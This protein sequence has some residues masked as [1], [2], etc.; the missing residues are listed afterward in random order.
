MWI[1]PNVS[2]HG[3]K[4][5]V[6]LEN[7]LYLEIAKANDG[8]DPDRLAVYAVFSAEHRIPLV[9]V[10]DSSSGGSSVDGYKHAQ[11]Y[12]ARIFEGVKGGYKILDLNE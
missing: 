5:A 1:I 2:G 7:A 12:I 8:R 9:E 11:G 6:N 4:P 10:I 3:Q